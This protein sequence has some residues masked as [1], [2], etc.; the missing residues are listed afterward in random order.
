M[1]LFF[2]SFSKI[3]HFLHK[4]VEIEFFYQP[5]CN[6]LK[7]YKQICL[8]VIVTIKRINVLEKCDNVNIKPN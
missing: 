2:R 8:G 3:P 4:I 1:T 5:H 6:I 7:N